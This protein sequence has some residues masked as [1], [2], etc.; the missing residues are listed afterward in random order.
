MGFVYV[1]HPNAE[2]LSLAHSCVGAAQCADCAADAAA[3]YP[4][5][6]SNR[7]QPVTLIGYV[8]AEPEIG[9]QLSTASPG[10][11]ASTEYPG[12]EI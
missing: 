2:E 10:R 4:L 3:H 6:I 11:G 12:R 8:A 9:S 1:G 7:L 5:Y